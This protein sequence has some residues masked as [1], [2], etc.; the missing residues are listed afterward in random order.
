MTKII[1]NND[2][3]KQLAKEVNEG[4]VDKL[5]AAKSIDLGTDGQAVAMALCTIANVLDE[6]ETRWD[7]DTGEAREYNSLSYVQKWILSGF[8]NTANRCVE[9]QEKQLSD[10]KDAAKKALRGHTGGEISDGQLK[11]ACDRYEQQQLQWAAAQSVYQAA[12][13]VFAEK[14]D[15]VFTPYQPKAASTQPKADKQ[16]T[17]GEA[18]R[19][20]VLLGV[21][22]SEQ[23]ETDG[24]E[25][26][27][28]QEAGLSR[29]QA[30]VK[31][32]RS[33]G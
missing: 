13:R 25:S 16:H 30:T 29:K 27:T 10:R 6:P 17:T 23:P 31:G 18:Q 2:V 5:A 26:A 21:E 14:Y 32:A 12:Q 4:K 3:A 24:V 33:S 1:S 19:A 22:L 9:V 28:E 20:A 8:C 11:Y 15:E 7:R